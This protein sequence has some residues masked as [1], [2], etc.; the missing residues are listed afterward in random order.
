MAEQNRAEGLKFDSIIEKMTINYETEIDPETTLE[1]RVRYVYCPVCD[2]TQKR[3][4]VPHLRD[5]HD[6]VWNIFLLKMVEMTNLG[7]RPMKIQHETF[8]TL[9]SW[10]VIQREMMMLKNERPEL[11][12]IKKVS[13]ADCLEP[14]VPVEAPNSIWSFKKRGDWATHSGQYMGNWPPQIAR[15]LISRYSEA[16]QLVV[17]PFLGGG[18]TMVEAMLL[19]RK[20]KGSDV[21]DWAIYSSKLQMSNLKKVDRKRFKKYRSNGL[22][23]A[24]VRQL[25]YLKNNS[26]DLFCTHPPYGYI[27]KYSSNEDDLSSLSIPLF[28]EALEESFATIIAKLKPG[29]YFAFM[30]GDIKKQGKTIPLHFYA[31]KICMELELELIEIAIKEQFNGTVIKYYPPDETFSRIIHEYVY[32]YQKPGINHQRTVSTKN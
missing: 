14:D 5:D 11:F 10:N 21:S 22:K 2:T 7:K 24:D 28:L 13:N 19:S 17:D 27:K 31:E 4:I 18:T 30:I 25:N 9:F 12:Q 20:F 26:V 15:I 32:V 1:K 3:T 8:S 29:G 23:V 6:E 16:G